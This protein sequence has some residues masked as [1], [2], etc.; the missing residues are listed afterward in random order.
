MLC[1]LLLTKIPEYKT[2]VTN[3]KRSIS[4]D[5]YNMTKDQKKKILLITLLLISLS[6]N[7]ITNKKLFY[8]ITDSITGDTLDEV[9]VKS[10][11][12]FAKKKG[13]K[14]IIQIKGIPFFMGKTFSE[15]LT[16]CP[17]ITQKEN[18]FNIL[19]K[20]S[21]AIY[22][23][24][25]P[26][27][28]T[29]DGLMAFLNSKNT[30]EIDHI[31]IIPNP[32]IKYPVSNKS[33]I[34]NIVT[35]VSNTNGVITNISESITKGKK[36]SERTNVFFG[37]NKKNLNINFFTNYAKMSKSRLS[38]TTYNFETNQLVSETSFFQQKA[39]PYTSML[40]AE[41]K[42]NNN[43]LGISYIHE[44][45]KL[46]E[47]GENT[48]IANDVISKKSHSANQNDILQIYDDYSFEKNTISLLYSFYYRNNRFNNDYI[49]KEI[50]NQYTY[51]KYEIN[52]LKLDVESQINNKWKIQYGLSGN[53]LRFVSNYALSNLKKQAQYDEKNMNIYFATSFDLHKVNI[54][55]GI[56]YEYTH[57][58]YIG[59]INNYKHAVPNFTATWEGKFGQMFIGYS[60]E[61]EKVSYTNLTISPVYF[62]PTSYVIGN[63]NLKPEIIHYIN[64][65]ISKGNL[66]IELYYK[67][68]KNSCIMF[69]IKDKE[70]I[71]NSY[72][73]LKS[74]EQYG[75]NMSFMKSFSTALLAKLSW[76]SYWDKAFITET[77]RNKSWNNFISTNFLVKLDN[78]NRFYININYWH[79]FPQKEHGVYWR[80]RSNLTLDATYNII[81]NKLKSTLSFGDIFNQDF[82]NNSRIYNN[83]CSYQ[84]NTFDNKKISLTM[85]YTISNKRL[86]KHIQ[87]N[88]VDES[89][90]ISSE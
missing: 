14:Y 59:N 24:G 81:K 52:N 43:R 79:L 65:G 85:I 61:V 64:C 53:I 19:G 56:K 17:L 72:S 75:I 77:E 9:I 71:I 86:V 11:Y 44:S 50:V 58:N 2:I 47:I 22:I 49:T 16:I 80:N 40:S 63:A 8:N 89:N 68:Y 84:K 31:E 33:G 4:T 27:S 57:Q 76:E 34:I 37:F 62:S 48:T 69:S 51:N 7:A 30:N 38:S 70:N 87:Q 21:T 83:I 60:K 32:S 46:N 3:P 45:L 6:S 39:T 41:S 20:E 66:N 13:D 90:R 15:G 88:I 25:K 78:K 10:Q 42:N 82:A 23:N 5:R 26:T 54:S 29:G 55:G 74:E 35:K 1:K 18:C 67:K 36:W 73:N 12:K 28:L